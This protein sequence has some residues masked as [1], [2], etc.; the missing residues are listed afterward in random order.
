MMELA[1]R[2]SVIAAV[3]SE[4]GQTMV[5]EGLEFMGATLAEPVKGFTGLLLTDK[6]N[7]RRWKNLVTIAVEA[8]HLLAKA[9]LSPKEI[10]LK[11][12]HP[13]LESASLEEEPDI[14]RVW[15]NLSHETKTGT[16]YPFTNMFKRNGTPAVPS[17]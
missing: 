4:L 14:Q 17:N 2:D 12:I 8:R 10:P 7:F 9:G 11:M 15:A 1:T 5:Q 13:L 16:G 3:T 6:I